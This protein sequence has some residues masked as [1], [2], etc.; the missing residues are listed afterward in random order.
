MN[1][2]RHKYI[3]N[4]YNMTQ[5][6]VSLSTTPLLPYDIVKCPEEQMSGS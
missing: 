1:T 5:T 4:F 3:I 6:N 2:K